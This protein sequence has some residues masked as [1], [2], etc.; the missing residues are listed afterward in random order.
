MDRTTVFNSTVAAAAH[1][2]DEKSAGD[3]IHRNLHA[4]ALIHPHTDDLKRLLS[5]EMFLKPNSAA[6]A[7]VFHYLFKILDA[8][9][10]RRSFRWPC[11]DKQDES[12]FRTAAVVLMNALIDRHKLPL[13]PVKMHSVVLPGGLK[14]MRIVYEFTAQAMRDTVAKHCPP[15]DDKYAFVCGASGCKFVYNANDKN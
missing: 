9:E 15:E 14:F 11:S 12:T 8:R 7:H 1:R 2:Q 13:E 10:F 4:L 6:F 5:P 3:E